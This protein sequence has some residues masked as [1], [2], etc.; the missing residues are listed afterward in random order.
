[1]LRLLYGP[2]VLIS[3]LIM[4][5]AMVAVAC[6]GEDATT[7]PAA[8]SAPA[9]TTAP[10][11]AA[12]SAPA[13]TSVPAPTVEPA[14]PVGAQPKVQTLVLGF[15]P[16]AGET[17]LHWAGTIDHHQ[18]FDLVS[19]VVVDIDPFTGSNSI[20]NPEL[21][22]SWELSEDGT[23]W[24][25]QL[26][27][28]VQFHNNW[29]EFT[30]ADLLH[31][32]AMM[33]RDDSLLAFSPDWREIDLEQTQAVGP[34]E[35]VLKLKNANPDFMFYLSPGGGGLMMS[36]AQWDA[37]G[38]AGYEQDI[39]GTGPYRYTGRTYGVDTHYERLP[40]HWRVKNDA[41]FEKVEIRW[42]QEFATRN[43]GLLAGE[44]H[45][46]EIPRD[47]A[48]NAVADHGMKVIASQQNAYLVFLAYQGQGP[49]EPGG[50]AA[51]HQYPDHPFNNLKF[52]EAMSKAIDL[53]KINR[54]LFYG[55]A[56]LNFTAAF[57]TTLAGWDPAWQTNFKTDYGYD[58]DRARELVIEAGYEDGAEIKGISMNFFGFPEYNDMMQAIQ[59]DFQAVGIDMQLEEWQ[60]NN[61]IAAARENK[62]EAT[63]L[64]IV[65]HSA[66]LA[67]AAIN[68]HNYSHGFLRF[69]PN[70][71]IDVLYE[72]LIQTVPADERERIQRE[73]GQIIYDNYGVGSVFNLSIEFTV[74]PEIVDQW[75][76]PG[77]DGANYGH[78]DLITACLTAE[79]CLE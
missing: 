55:S 31:S 57:A 33:Q 42:I 18:Q 13:A 67:Q 41:A 53:D 40:D 20:F 72:Q 12:T 2:R 27:E 10:Q 43:A 36:K 50:F 49:A 37:E 25:L 66:F 52:R 61:Y 68:I 59:L 58:P 46:T 69:Y 6:G 73:I 70:E 3:V 78:L 75:H 30:S 54:N 79:P 26:E 19:E 17:N 56:K 47:L 4:L 64:W 32:V 29:G 74:N 15:D 35:V 71:Q 65:P 62:P 60:F 22:K 11:P 34:Y 45:I 77:D 39:I 51:G 76:Y 38:D 28:G 16:A 14:A 24:R 8:T 7:A 9:A 23:E 44:I 1:M 5:A 48:A 63:A 21:A